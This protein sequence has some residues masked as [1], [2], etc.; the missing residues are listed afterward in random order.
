MTEQRKRSKTGTALE[1]DYMTWLG[2]TFRPELAYP[3]LSEDMIER[4][5]SY[6]HEESFPADICLYSHGDRNLDLFIVLEGGID[7][8]LP[9]GPDGSKVYNE[10]RVSNFTGEYNLSTP[11]VPL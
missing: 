1:A 6:G 7:V 10:I 5:R 11:K 3:K 9:D 8:S 2:T 4:L